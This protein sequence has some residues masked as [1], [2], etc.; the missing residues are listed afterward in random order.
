[1]RAFIARLKNALS[2]CSVSPRPPTDVATSLE[3]NHNILKQNDTEPHCVF[4]GRSHLMK[5]ETNLDLQNAKDKAKEVLKSFY[6]WGR[7]K[8]ADLSD[9][10]HSSA[11][12]AM[13]MIASPTNE[14]IKL[15]KTWMV[16]NDTK[17]MCA[18]FKAEWQ[19]VC[20][21]CVG[22]VD[23]IMPADRDCIILGAKKM[24]HDVNFN[25]STF[26]VR[27]RNSDLLHKDENT[28]FQHDPCNYPLIASLLGHDYMSRI[29]NADFD[30]L[31]NE[32]FP[33]LVAW[34]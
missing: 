18:L 4:D 26:K 11:M 1:M 23:A 14:F 16:E 24:H 29:K 7:D 25:K 22:A 32:M 33:K 30:A 15:V 27:D 12:T 34:K 21:E 20:L 31:F 13:K 9:E 5:C 8:N 2:I 17:F 28:L 19:C 6:D 10:D 3:V